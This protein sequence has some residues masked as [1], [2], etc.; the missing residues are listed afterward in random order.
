MPVL[1]V[2][3]LSENVLYLFIAHQPR[4]TRSR[5]EYRRRKNRAEFDERRRENV[6]LRRFSLKTII[7]VPD[8][9]QYLRIQ[10]HLAVILRFA[11]VRRTRIRKS[12]SRVTLM[13]GELAR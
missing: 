6:H 4:V 11:R 3:T 1:N 5:S 10:N 9:I 7:L 2:S 13:Q 12:H 8:T